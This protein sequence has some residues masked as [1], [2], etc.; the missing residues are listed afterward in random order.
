MEVR[1]V[2]HL[3]ATDLRGVI[4][5]PKMDSPASTE[6]PLGEAI[7]A[8]DHQMEAHLAVRGGQTITMTE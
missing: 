6:D 8:E 3:T 5:H 1:G 2:T 7:Q 4:A